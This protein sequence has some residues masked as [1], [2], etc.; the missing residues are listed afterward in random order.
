MS[1]AALVTLTSVV[2]VVVSARAVPVAATE[3]S[4]R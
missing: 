3:P 2:K 4:A 1:A